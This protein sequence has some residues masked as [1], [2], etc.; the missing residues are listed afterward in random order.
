MKVNIVKSKR[1]KDS[2]KTYEHYVSDL[3]S[4]NAIEVI[5]TKVMVYTSIHKDNRIYGFILYRHH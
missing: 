5:V 4:N 3:I 2:S 1:F